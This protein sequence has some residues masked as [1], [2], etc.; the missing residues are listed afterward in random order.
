MRSRWARTIRPHR[1]K[2]GILDTR[3]ARTETGVTRRPPS[4]ETPAK[5]ATRAEDDLTEAASKMTL[6]SL[7]PRDAEETEKLRQEGNALYRQERYA[8]ADAERIVERSPSSRRRR[9][10]TPERTIR[11]LWA[12]RSTHSSVVRPP[13]S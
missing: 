8:E 11:I 1:D 3:S 6:D 7:A 10:R 9:E 2:V 12:N 5:F 4:N 13:C